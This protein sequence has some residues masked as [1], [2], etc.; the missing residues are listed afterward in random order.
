M[1]RIAE[2]FEVPGKYDPANEREALSLMFGAQVTRSVE[3]LSIEAAEQRR[4]RMSA[5]DIEEARRGVIKFQAALTGEVVSEKELRCMGDGKF[6]LE[7]E[8]KALAAQVLMD[9]FVKLV[10]EGRDPRGV[11]GDDEMKKMIDGLDVMTRARLPAGRLELV[12][13]HVAAEILGAANI[14]RAE[15]QKVLSRG[16]HLQVRYHPVPAG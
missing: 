3:C 13:A 2:L 14:L 15:A 6:A 12:T 11:Y 8:E 10:D 5:A 7:A 4:L 16:A 1:Q 9:I